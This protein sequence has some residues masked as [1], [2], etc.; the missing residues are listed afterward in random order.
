MSE[1]FGQKC[2]SVKNNCHTMN[3][4]RFHLFTDYLLIVLCFFSMRSETVSCQL[5]SSAAS[6]QN[7]NFVVS[8]FWN[9]AQHRAVRRRL[10]SLIRRYRPIWELLYA[11]IMCFGVL[12]SYYV[13]FIIVCTMYFCAICIMCAYA[14]VLL[15][16]W[17]KKSLAGYCIVT[18]VRYISRYLYTVECIS[19]VI[20]VSITWNHRTA[21]PSA[22]IGMYDYF[23][24][25]GKCAPTL[26]AVIMTLRCCDI[27]IWANRLD[28]Y[29]Q[30]AIAIPYVKGGPEK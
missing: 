2:F 29:Q 8:P 4:M 5:L 7:N 9:A 28:I 16:I 23:C 1:L 13:C 21:N 11:V 27:V 30:H 10:S 3:T 18:M 6:A 26:Y 22:Y 12:C 19:F 14:W 17:R 20:N 15:V 24:D 25:T